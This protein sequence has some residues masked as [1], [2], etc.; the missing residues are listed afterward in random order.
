MLGGLLFG[1]YGD[2]MRFPVF[3]VGVC[4][5]FVDGECGDLKLVKIALYCRVESEHSPD[6]CFSVGS[7]AARGSV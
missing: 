5:S 1:V 6:S 2:W 7:G 3:D 4:E